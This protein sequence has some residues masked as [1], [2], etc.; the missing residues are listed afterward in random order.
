M[1]SRC[2]G[3]VKMLAGFATLLTYHH[4]EPSGA[5]GPHEDEIQVLAGTLEMRP[6]S[7]KTEKGQ[8]YLSSFFPPLPLC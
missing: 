5:L 8:R 4:T 3:T 1:V 6:S 7:I 2:C